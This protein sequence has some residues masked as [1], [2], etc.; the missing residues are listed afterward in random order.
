MC[1]CVAVCTYLYVHVYSC[2]GHWLCVCISVYVCM[3]TV[4][5]K[6]LITQPVNSTVD[7]FKHIQ[8]QKIIVMIEG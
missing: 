2:V 1:M 8:V 4:L 5:L 7:N 3:L 6:K